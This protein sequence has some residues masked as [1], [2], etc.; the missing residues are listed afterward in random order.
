MATDLSS[1]GRILALD[2]GRARIGVAVSDLLGWTAQP[3]ETIR[4]RSRRQV[5]TRIRDLVREY[6]ISIILLGMPY[7]MDGSEG[8]QANWVRKFGEQLSLAIKRPDVVYWDERLTTFES[9]SFLAEAGV[10]SRKRKQ[11]RDKIAAALILKD[12]LDAQR[13]RTA[14]SRSASSA[15]SNSKITGENQL[16]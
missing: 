3:L 8:P 9:E 1:L 5:I 4:V 14:K 12:Y 7:N 13:S 2:L 10:K 15:D 6:E 11:Y 16:P